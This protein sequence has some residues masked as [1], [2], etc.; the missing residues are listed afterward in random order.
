MPTIKQKKKTRRP[1][2][3]ARLPK[4]VEALLNYLGPASMGAP[5]IQQ[6]GQRFATSVGGGGE[7][8]G[9]AT[10]VAEAVV[11]R[12][13]AM[14]MARLKTGA[15][16]LKPS[17]VSTLI[18]QQQ[19]QTI[20]IQQQLPTQAQAQAQAT[21]ELMRETLAKRTQL[22]N[23]AKRLEADVDRLQKEQRQRQGS[24]P[25]PPPP[26]EPTELLL[27]PIAASGVGEFLAGQ[28]QQSLATAELPPAQ[29]LRGKAPK[30]PKPPKE[31]KARGRPKKATAEASGAT[32]SFSQAVS[33]LA[34]IAAAATPKSI[35]SA[36]S[37]ASTGSSISR[38]RE[39]YET[40][41]R[42]GMMGGDVVSAMV[43]G[44]AAAPEPVQ[45]GQ[46]LGEIMYRTDKK[47]KR[48]KVLQA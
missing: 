15:E 26:Q 9:F 1:R 3:P 38:A 43:S 30:E 39:I 47:G 21:P 18:P 23:Y 34:S 12:Q 40:A 42:R 14:K 28:Y 24:I 41:T 19:P 4:A 17:L 33:G 10:Q 11:A 7:Q 25:L 6:S 45:L 13:Q 20:I 36:S 44:G 5:T 32:Q 31:P 8:K 22:E 35:S 16:Q 27:E 29:K 46:S 48:M 37:V 2:K